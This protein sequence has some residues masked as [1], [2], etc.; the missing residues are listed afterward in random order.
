VFEHVSE[1]Y[2]QIDDQLQDFHAASAEQCLSNPDGAFMLR[3]GWKLY[4]RVH[5]YER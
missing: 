3:M 1:P 5:H 2:K 4:G